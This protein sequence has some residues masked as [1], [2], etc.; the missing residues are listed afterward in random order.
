MLHRIP[1]IAC[2][3]EAVNVDAEHEEA[4]DGRCRE[5]GD[6]EEHAEQRD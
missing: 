1:G 3:A 5:S 4:G 2:E 6:P